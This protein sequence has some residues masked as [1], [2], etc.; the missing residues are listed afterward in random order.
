MPE[1]VERAGGVSVIGQAGERSCES[2]WEALAA[3][4]PEVVV[5]GLCGF[6]LPR[7][8][9]EWAAF[10]VPEPLPR[11]RGLADRSAMGDRRVG[12]RLAPR[13]APGRR[14]GDPEPR[15]DRCRGSPCGA[16]SDRRLRRASF[17]VPTH[18]LGATLLSVQR[19]PGELGRPGCSIST[20]LPLTTVKAITASL[21][22]AEDHR[23]LP[24]VDQGRTRAAGQ[25]AEAEGALGHR[26]ATAQRGRRS[27]PAHPRR[28]ARRR[29]DRGPRAAPGN[30][31]A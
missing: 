19:S 7:T 4:E 28:R 3:A 13:T 21:V 12:L 30:R 6:D 24:P 16:A 31:P 27:G 17:V 15:P 23:S 2:S 25:A 8:L 22:A 14:S 26:L 20:T 18:V 29:P 5:L 9:E 11:T 10:K 1:Q